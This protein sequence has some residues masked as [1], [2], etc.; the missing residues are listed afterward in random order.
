MEN[1]ISKKTKTFLCVKYIMFFALFYVLS[2]AGINGFVFPFYFGVFFALLW[3]NQNVLVLSP[4]YVGARYLTAFSLYD[5]YGALFMVVVI[6]IIYGVH[7]KLKKPIREIMFL[8]Y[9]LLGIFADVFFKI[10]FGANIILQTI[11]VVFGLLFMFATMKFF[12][13]IIVRG[14]RGKMT[15]LEL[16]CGGSVIVAIFCG[17][18]TFEIWGFE[19]VKLFAFFV[20]LFFAF[21]FD[22]KSTLFVCAVMGIGTIL[23]SNNAFLFAPFVLWGIVC[24]CFRTRYRIVMVVAK[25][26]LAYSLHSVLYAS[27]LFAGT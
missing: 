6:T 1:I 16:I 26:L 20:T 9:A 25:I 8:P 4:L 13:V 17:L 10:Y 27:T 21:S 5:L 18:S 7:Q 11:E 14:V 12:E 15:S 22:A 19:F 23:N 3:C 24:V 2:K